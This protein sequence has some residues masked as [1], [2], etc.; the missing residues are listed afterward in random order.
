MGMADVHKHSRPSGVV[1]LAL[2]LEWQDPPAEDVTCQVCHSRQP[3]EWCIIWR[4]NG[5]VLWTGL[6]EDCRRALE[7][8]ARE[9]DGGPE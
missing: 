5:V 1:S 7:R 2:P 6:H 9:Q 3:V 8:R 4:A